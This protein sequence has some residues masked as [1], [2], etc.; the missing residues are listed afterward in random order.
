MPPLVEVLKVGMSTHY[1]IINSIP[2]KWDGIGHTMS[3]GFLLRWDKACKKVKWLD[4]NILSNPPDVLRPQFQNW[5]KWFNICNCKQAQDTSQRAQCSEKESAK[6]TY[7]SITG[8]STQTENHQQDIP[9][10]DF[11]PKTDNFWRSLDHTV[12]CLNMLNHG[13]K[14]ISF[15]QLGKGISS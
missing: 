1:R 10:L 11:S 2:K 15:N 4:G 14:A 8:I 5:N 6:G 13:Q 7:S 12:L 9:V 3:R